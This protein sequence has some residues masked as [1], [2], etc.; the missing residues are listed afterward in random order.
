MRTIATIIVSLMTMATQAQ[1][2][3]TKATNAF[4]GT[5]R[6][7]MQQVRCI[8]KQE[9]ARCWD[10][11]NMEI[12]IPKYTV[13][14]VD[15]GDS[16]QQLTS[17]IESGTRYMY[18]M[19]GDSLLINGYRG[20]F[21]EVNY[22]ERE[23]SLLLP[24]NMGDSVKGIFHGRG[25]YGDKMA[26]RHYGRYMTKA[27]AIGTLLLPDNDSLRNVLR[28][29]TERLIASKYYP[30]TQLD[31]LAPYTADS[32]F[33]NL[34]KDTTV[35]RAVIDRWFAPG[36]RYPVI[37]RRM[38]SV[39]DE[40]SQLCQTLY[41][42]IEQQESDCTDDSENAKIRALYAERQEQEKFINN[43]E[44]D[45]SENV[46]QIQ[47][48]KTNVNGGT[49]TV[50]YDL[51]ADATVTALVCDVSGVVYR[52]QSQTGQAGD[53]YQMTI[54]CNGLRRGQYVL[55]L[56]ANGQVSSQTISL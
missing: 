9:N 1:T 36:Y 33:M 45:P 7:T 43:P 49:V 17:V 15:K 34:Q 27:D 13:W 31:S 44:H 19:Q 25:T 30:I 28:L 11:S 16:L 53:S 50:S 18:C 14:H 24:M 22:D 23:I 10:F 2:V 8:E 35:I 4:A 29:H 48:I 42:P 21:S 26:M 51:L 37:E 39:A 55:Y 20:R 6:H 54:L 38:I 41:Y 47:N 5:G 32:V 12:D 46:Q 40:E 56:N 3:L 52:Q